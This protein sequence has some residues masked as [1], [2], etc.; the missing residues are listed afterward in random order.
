MQSA[1]TEDLKEY[2]RRDVRLRNNKQKTVNAIVS[3]YR[4]LRSRDY[5]RPWQLQVL[6][7]HVD[8]TSARCRL[9]TKLT[10]KSDALGYREHAI[11]SMINPHVIIVARV[12]DL[13]TR[14]E[15]SDLAG[16]RFGGNFV[17][18]KAEEAYYA[19]AGDPNWKFRTEWL[20]RLKPGVCSWLCFSLPAL[21]LRSLPEN[22]VARGW[23]R[24][25]PRPSAGLGA[26]RPS[27]AVRMQRKDTGRFST[28]PV[29]ASFRGRGQRGKSTRAGMERGW[30][31][32]HKV[33]HFPGLGMPR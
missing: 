7:R 23:P 8:S 15:P 20:P 6:S 17:E 19:R 18:S 29:N 14:T 27:L 1:S 30:L 21:W 32:P 11:G 5:P 33:G 2:S 22:C 3:K 9:R 13:D 31:G 26:Q 12:G 25:D 10:R 28:I 24:R 4:R 16:D